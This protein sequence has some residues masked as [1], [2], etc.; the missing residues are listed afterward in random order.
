MRRGAAVI[1]FV[2]V[3]VALL[4]L[5]AGAKPDEV[6]YGRLHQ[7]DVEI[8]MTV[9]ATDAQVDGMERHVRGAS[10]VGRYAQLD[11]HDAFHEFQRIFARNRKLV[12]S[13]QADDLPQS[14]RV[15]LVHDDH[16][17]GF[18]RGV[19]HFPGVD[20][21]TTPRQDAPKQ[22]VALLAMIR[23]C[24]T[25]EVDLEIF[26]EVNATQAEID[27]ATQAVTAE[28]GLTVLR[29]LS[30][31]DAY[32]E[33]Q[34][35]FASN[36]ALVE[37]ISAADLPVSIRVRTARRVPDE[38]IARLGSVPG[39]ESVETPHVVCDSIRSLLQQGLTPKEVAR[40]MAR[41]GGA[42]P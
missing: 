20:T 14:F 23:G 35:T 27:A 37:S 10:A 25:N 11:E 19:R 38:T 33:F 12:K 41:F 32:A 5:P 26:M 7:P 17:S 15:D 34:S 8:F 36:P 39:V 6:P 13:V 4:G 3:A 16:A 18:A 21:V 40:L 31:D 42:V 22:A 1:G 24:Q 29:V 9:D 30:K 2:V 28:S